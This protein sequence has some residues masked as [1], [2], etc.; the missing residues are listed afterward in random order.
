MSQYGN[1]SMSI[2]TNFAEN[3]NHRGKYFYFSS[4]DVAW[5]RADSC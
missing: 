1:K 3:N 2:F 5:L 4:K